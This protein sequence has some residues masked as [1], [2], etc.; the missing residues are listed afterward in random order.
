MKIGRGVKRR[1][2]TK[3]VKRERVVKQLKTVIKCKNQIN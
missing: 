2:G 3:L 1:V